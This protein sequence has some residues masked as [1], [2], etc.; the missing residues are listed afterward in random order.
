MLMRSE[1]VVALPVLGAHHLQTEVQGH[2]VVD[3]KALQE[4]VVL[5]FILAHL[6]FLR[7]GKDTMVAPPMLTAELV[8][9]VQVAPELQI[10]EVLVVTEVWE[11]HH[12]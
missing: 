10:L 12:L 1:E 9:V 6:L 5:V 3:L 11:Q 7:Q 2:P 8:V 4:V